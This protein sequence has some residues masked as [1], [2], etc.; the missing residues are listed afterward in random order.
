MCK[1]YIAQYKHEKEIFDVK[2]RHH[3]DELELETS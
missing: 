3:I 2:E 1:N